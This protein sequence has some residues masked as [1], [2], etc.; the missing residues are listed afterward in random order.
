M[1]YFLLYFCTLISF[2]SF[3][4]DTISLS[5]QNDTLPVDS[6]VTDNSSS[7]IIQLTEEQQTTLNNSLN[8][9]KKK[10]NIE[11]VRILIGFN[12][13][14]YQPL[15]T[16][17]DIFIGSYYPVKDSSPVWTERSTK[18]NLAK[19]YKSSNIQF[20]L[21]GN[22][23]KGL[24]VGMNY[25]FFTVRKYKKDPNRGNLLSRTNAMFFL[26]SAQFGYVF[27][28]L[29]DKTLQIHPSIRIGGYTADDYYDSGKG[30]KFYFGTDLQIRYLIKR[31]A[32]FSVGFNY[33]FLRYKQKG[34]SDIFMR[35]T[36][37]KT[38]FSNLHLNAGVF[39][40]ISIKTKQ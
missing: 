3:S 27:E 18:A 31:K 8:S 10:I 7:G 2:Y 37:Q 38:S 40:N 25:Q 35:D 19:T 32:G 39:V 23:W 21:Q 14:F 34:Y 36:Y 29:K 9:K 22:V 24:F 12:Y 26:V 28:F 16:E 4:Q 20:S 15:M 17:R 5:T 13:S 11:R 30:K 33:D 1:K 6:I